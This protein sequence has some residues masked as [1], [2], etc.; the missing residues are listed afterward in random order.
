LLPGIV[1]HGATNPSIYTVHPIVM[2][3]FSQHS[4]N[5]ILCYLQPFNQTSLLSLYVREIGQRKISIWRE[6]EPKFE[7]TIR[8]NSAIRHAYGGWRLR[9]T[10]CSRSLPSC[11]HGVRGSCHRYQAQDRKRKIPT[12]RSIAANNEGEEPE[13]ALAAETVHV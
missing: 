11:L 5:H 9:L 3:R 2:W 1:V 12:E 6:E 8:L 13:T 10:A 7:V 4:L